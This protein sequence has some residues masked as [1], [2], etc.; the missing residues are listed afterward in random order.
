MREGHC[1][2]NGDGH[3]PAN[4]KPLYFQLPAY[5]NG[6]SVYNNPPPPP[7]PYKKG[8]L[9]VPSGR[10]RGCG[11]TYFLGF[12]EPQAFSGGGRH[13]HRPPAS[14]PRLLAA[15]TPPDSRHPR[16]PLVLP[17]SGENEVRPRPRPNP[18]AGPARSPEPGSQP[19]P[20]PSPR[21]PAPR[22]L[23]R[24]EVGRPA[25]GGPEVGGPAP[26]PGSRRPA[27]RPRS[28]PRARAR[29]VECSVG[30]GV[31]PPSR[32][33]GGRRVGGGA[34]QSCGK[35]A[36]RAGPGGGGRAGPAAAELL[37]GVT[38]PAC[39]GGSRAVDRDPGPERRS[40]V[41]LYCR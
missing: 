22:A 40:G 39:V 24:P 20:R 35:R 18:E 25:P 4:E 37:S 8:L 27:A 17:P 41:V 11:G 26:N 23:R 13:Q 6:L 29:G 7:T 14:C 10:A 21:R 9:R 30:A 38:R 28:R 36:G 33:A 34:S 19:R 3:S 32:A 12:S 2:A 31:G 1:P 5:S 16:E 15:G